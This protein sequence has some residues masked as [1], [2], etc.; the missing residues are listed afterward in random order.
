MVF[1]YLIEMDYQ[2]GFYRTIL[3]RGASR[4]SF[5]L[6]RMLVDLFVN[7]IIFEVIVVVQVIFGIDTEGWQALGFLW[8]IS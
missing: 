3:M 6:P 2:Q 8:L 7:L 4:S 1:F 5:I